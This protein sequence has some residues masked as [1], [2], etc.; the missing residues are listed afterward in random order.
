MASPLAAFLGLVLPL[1]ALAC[2]SDASPT[3]TPTRATAV[4]V[5]TVTADP[6]LL[7]S[8]TSVTGGEPSAEVGADLVLA[9]GCLACHST[10]GAALVGPTWQGLY[11]TQ[12]ELED[13]SSVTVDA[14][15]IAESIREP[16]AKITAGFTGGLMP[17]TLG[18][19]DE[20]IPHIV[21]Y[22]RSLR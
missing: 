5:P 13:G 3:A 7:A 11:G 8:L 17:A 12:E 14:Q 10:D 1:L 9:Y 6:T 20:E 2:G 18:V 4:P 16:D 22:I 19:K 21:E 15:Y